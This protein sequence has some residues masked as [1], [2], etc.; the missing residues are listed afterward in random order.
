[1]SYTEQEIP[2]TARPPT[3]PP[4]RQLATYH[5]FL[6]AARYVVLA[7]VVIG[8]FLIV[9]FCT[10]TPWLWVIAISVAELLVGLYFARDRKQV[11][12]TSEFAT[13]FMTTAAEGGR[14]PSLRT[15]APKAGS[16]PLHPAG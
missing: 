4:K 5:H 12:W 7:H 11:T 2:D 9:G 3:A 8:T 15:G 1:M 14:H 6:I 13:L 10:R 16:R